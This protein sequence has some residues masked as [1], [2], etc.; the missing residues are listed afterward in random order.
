M[1]DQKSPPLNV[2]A[3]T[4]TGVLSGAEYVL[5]RHALTGASFGD[6][7]IIA[8]PKGPTAARLEAEGLEHLPIPEL[9]LGS[10][11]RPLAA[12]LLVAR[13]LRAMIKLRRA[14]RQADV[15]VSNSV[16]C[17]PVLRILRPSAP[18][19]WLVHDVI[20][21]GDLAKI[22][23]WSAP[24]VA[25]SLPVSKASAALSLEL[26]IPTTVV[27]NG[28]EIVD[29]SMHTELPGPPIIGL[30]AVL[31][32]WK[33]QHLLLEAAALVEEPIVVELLGGALPKDDAYERQLR[34]RASHSDLAGK[35]R[36]LGHLS[37]PAAA[38][39]HWTIAVSASV[40]PEA[41]PLSVLE[42][43]CLGVPVV[44]SNHGGAPEVAG[45]AG[46]L[47]PVGDAEA[48]AQAI[49]ELISDPERRRVLGHAAKKRADD[50]FDRPVLEAQFREV[51]AELAA[52]AR[53]STA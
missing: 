3:L 29:A 30:N 47:V 36:F 52:S 31:T 26:G 48:L 4:P 38:M 12:I 28:I 1:T 24:C 19:A 10:G 50:D 51:L 6:R 20:T 21:R 53:A 18:V 41:G 40:E 46:V 8:A 34:E 42:A 45:D 7:W 27:Y 32:H 16:L 43:M 5:I 39:R 44:V 9:K 33:G 49:R 11:P 13:N 35:V 37:T 25:R 23:R 22:A 15:I 14:V 17:L 2:L